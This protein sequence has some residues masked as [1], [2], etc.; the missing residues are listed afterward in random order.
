[1]FKVSCDFSLTIS[2]LKCTINWLLHLTVK[3]FW[4]QT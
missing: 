1:M 4:L 2:G 3:E